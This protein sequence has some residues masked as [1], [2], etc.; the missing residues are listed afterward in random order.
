MRRM[1]GVLSNKENV[2]QIK[3]RLANIRKA[4]KL[5]KFFEDYKC[6]ENLT[7]VWGDFQKVKSQSAT[8]SL[9]SL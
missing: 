8:N 4:D 1:F 6:T 9:F 2:S 7:E 5:E 3:N